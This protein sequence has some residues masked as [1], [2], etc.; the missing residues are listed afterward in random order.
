MHGIRWLLI[1]LLV[2][3]LLFSITSGSFLVIGSPQKADVILV[4]AGETDHRPS[5][6]LQLLREGYAPKVLLDVPAA[7]MLYGQSTLDVARAFVQRLPQRASVS[8]CPV[9]G[10]STK[11]ETQDADVCLK[12]LRAHTV[13]IVTSDYHTRRALSVFQHELPEYQFSIAAAND[14]QQF[15]TSWWDHR[16]WAKLNFDEWVRLVWWCLVDRWL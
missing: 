2:A 3:L 16:Q 7:A 14:S 12:Q 4:L 6:G 1:V 15:G 8:V 13:L 10:L 9:F 5:R 11:Q